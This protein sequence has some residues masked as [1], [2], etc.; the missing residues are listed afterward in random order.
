MKSLILDGNNIVFRA[1]HIPRKPQIINNVNISPVL[2]FFS[3]VK[4]YINKFKPTN[5]YIAWD[6]KLN[7]EYKS[8]NNFRK[9]LVPY[10]EN[11]PD[12]PEIS[13]IY[14]CI[15]VIINLTESM[16]FKNMFPWNLEAD[17]VIH[18]IINNTVGDKIIISSDRDLLQLVSDEVTCYNTIKNDIVSLDN[19]EEHVGLP[20]DTFILYK[21][22][23]GDKSDNIPGLEKYGEVR[24]KKLASNYDE[25]T[26]SSEQLKII[27]R[28][29]LLID[30]SL[31]L[32]QSPDDL[33]SLTEQKEKCKSIKFNE[34]KFRE[35]CLTYGL[36][37]MLK[38]TEDWKYALNSRSLLEEWF[39]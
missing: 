37:T 11:R 20:I 24:S 38:D 12:R 36:S 31:G 30:L 10:K 19:F 26:L 17:D 25:S 14:D 33:I 29:K 18:F 34:T 21:C 2:Q 7:T 22:I 1:Y 9:T 4:S 13:D 15:D 28:N 5:V 3:M 35:L 6:K 39:N 32:D 27:E 23:L 16:G 8:E